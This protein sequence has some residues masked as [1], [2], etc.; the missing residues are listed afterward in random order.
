M[1]RFLNYKGTQRNLRKKK[2]KTNAGFLLVTC[3]CKYHVGLL[4]LLYGWKNMRT[5]VKG[6]HGRNCQCK[7]D[8]CARGVFGTCMAKCT[9][10]SGLSDMWMSILCPVETD[11]W[12]NLHYLMGQCKDCGVDMLV[13]CSTKYNPG[14]EKLVHWNCY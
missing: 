10:F 13:T 6:V 1:V 12:Y 14:S 9:H 3:A 7:C 2:S 11:R 4:E 8:V 5:R